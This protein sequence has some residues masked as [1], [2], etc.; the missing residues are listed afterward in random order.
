MAVLLDDT[1]GR[2]H[3]VISFAQQMS[4]RY[5]E[6]VVVVDGWEYPQSIVYTIDF[7]G[8]IPPDIEHVT[9]RLKSKH[10]LSRSIDSI[11]VQ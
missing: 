8:E 3:S 1:F 6:G 11:P 10:G 4:E 2:W 7:D 9:L 5:E